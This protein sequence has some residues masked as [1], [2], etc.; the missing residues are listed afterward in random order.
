MKY[1]NKAGGEI[2]STLN[3]VIERVDKVKP[4]T[5]D[6]NT[7]ADWLYRLDGRLSREVFQ[8][9]PPTQYTHPE[10]DDRELLVG[11]PYDNMYDLYLQAMISYQDKEYADYNNAIQLFEKIYSEHAKWYIRENTPKSHGTFTG[12]Y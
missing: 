4:N 6:D 5:Y 9:E 2:I 12:T 7:K 11:F 10:D 8:T 3:E 1:L